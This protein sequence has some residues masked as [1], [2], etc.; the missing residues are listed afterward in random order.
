M[1]FWLLNM[2]RKTS[3]RNGAV[4]LIGPRY[5]RKQRPLLII[6]K[7]KEIYMQREDM[8]DEDEKTVLRIFGDW[9]TYY[10]SLPST[11]WV[12]TGR[13]NNNGE[14]MWAGKPQ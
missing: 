2:Q 3:Q 4:S 8:T 13:N 7:S 11:K 10:K 5:T 6:L 14:P 12:R 1:R 9:E